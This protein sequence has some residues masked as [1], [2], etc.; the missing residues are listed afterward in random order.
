MRSLLLVVSRPVNVPVVPV[1]ADAWNGAAAMVILLVASAVAV[2]Q[3]ANK[4]A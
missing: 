4:L 1:I 2:R 3:L